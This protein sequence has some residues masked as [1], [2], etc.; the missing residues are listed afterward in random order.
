MTNISASMRGNSLPL[1]L[2]GT[3]LGLMLTRS[4]RDSDGYHGGFNLYR[5]DEAG[6]LMRRT[7]DPTAGFGYD[8]DDY[9]ATR[10]SARGMISSAGERLTSLRDN[11]TDSVSS[12]RDTVTDSVSSATD[13]VTSRVSDMTDRASDYTQRARSGLSTL[14]TEQP[15]VLGALGLLAGAA[16]AAMVPR[17]HMEEE[18]MGEAAQ[19]LREEARNTAT[20]TYERAKSAA[21]KAAEAASQ[22]FSGE[23]QD[24][25]GKTESSGGPQSAQGVSSPGG[26]SAA[27]AKALGL[28]SGAGGARPS[29]TIS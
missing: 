13:L 25:K 18:Y 12:M 11:M 24:D 19:R 8:E 5:D 16:L 10:S 23:Q 15:L 22:E 21:Q 28:Q 14:A 29:E 4:F 3:G 17:T 6:D 27:G 9:R 7:A 26:T 1:L 20:E 2:I